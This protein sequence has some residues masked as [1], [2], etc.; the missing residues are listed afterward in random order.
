MAKS[1]KNMTSREI[2]YA[3]Y[4]AIV[5]NDVDRAKELLFARIDFKEFSST[6]ANLSKFD[7]KQLKLLS[8][9]YPNPNW[10]EYVKDNIKKWDQIIPFLTFAKEANIDLSKKDSDGVSIL[11]NLFKRTNYEYLYHKGLYN[12]IDNKYKI[13]FEKDVEEPINDKNGI[14]ILLKHL[15]KSSDLNVTETSSILNSLVAESPNASKLYSYLLTQENPFSTFIYNNLSSKNIDKFI[16]LNEK[17]LT[18]EVTNY[19]ISNDV[20]LSVFRGEGISE[21][22][23]D[24]GIQLIRG[25]ELNPLLK[26]LNSENQK[27][28]NSGK[29]PYLNPF[30]LST[31]LYLEMAKAKNAFVKNSS[32]TLEKTIFERILIKG[33]RSAHNEAYDNEMTKKNSFLKDELKSN[34]EFKT[35]K[36]I[37]T[38]SLSELRIATIQE[39]K[40]VLEFANEVLD[41]GFEPKFNLTTI[42]EAKTLFSEG[43]DY[44]KFI[45]MRSFSEEKEE[46]SD[47]V[48]EL[49]TQLRM[50]PDIAQE[51]FEFFEKNYGFKPNPPKQTIDHQESQLKEEVLVMWNNL[52][53]KII[54][55]KVEETIPKTKKPK[56]KN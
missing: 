3:G 35:R 21:I 1:I 27:I 12:I 2:V 5:S 37:V 47:N 7:D 8:E 44:K 39:I 52:V 26:V 23:Y 38:P 50:P 18:K 56:V 53:E 48:L 36:K 32:E 25:N 49:S 11:T 51:V 46:F 19:L 28:I 20:L 34:D 13:F 45:R 29:A 40:N 30:D 17:H 15:S 14:V 41:A 55:N 42:E 24:K 22:M 16:Q 33:L 31:K 43:L 10:N 9:V 54:E 4:E 6:I